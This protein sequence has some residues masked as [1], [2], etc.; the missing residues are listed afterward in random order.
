[1]WAI[2]EYRFLRWADKNLF[3]IPIIGFLLSIPFKCVIRRIIFAFSGIELSLGTKIGPGIDIAHPGG[4]LIVADSIDR[5]CFFGNYVMI[6]SGKDGYPKLGK[7]VVCHSGSKIFGGITIGDNVII[8]ANSVVNKS[9][10]S[11]VVIAGI[12][13][14][15][16]RK[17]YQF[18]QR[19][20]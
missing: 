10:P 6:G 9:F 16:I 11:N 3:N 7:H 12:P 1:M 17:N 4:L 8:G 5:N 20:D 13:A 15:I 2:T 18:K 19:V 14:K